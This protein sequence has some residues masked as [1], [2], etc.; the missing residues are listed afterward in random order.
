MN[1]IGW[2]TFTLIE[3]LV[4]IAIIAIL[5]GLLLPALAKARDKGM[6]IAC[7][8]QLK[9]TGLLMANYNN[10]FRDWYP[11]APTA[12]NITNCWTR[13]LAE[14]YLNCKFTTAGAFQGSSKYY[15]CPK[16]IDGGF[17]NRPRGYAMNGLAAGILGTSEILWDVCM[18]NRSYK[19]N[20]MMMLVAEFW[21]QTSHKETY[22]F[23]NINNGEYLSYAHGPR[24]ATRHGNRNFNYLVK[25]G[26]V[27]QNGRRWDSDNLVGFDVVWGLKKD[28]F[29]K[30]GDFNQPY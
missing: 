25:N 27:L 21:D 9:Q 26:A 20:S 13:Q 4:V 29:W 11:A 23:G 22:A 18:Q 12:S 8:G 30:N 1:R 5:A 28:S 14:L 2:K 17:S 16:G 19:N 15:H 10:D 6:D 24:V 3:L 7:R